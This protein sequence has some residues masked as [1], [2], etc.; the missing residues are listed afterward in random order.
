MFNLLRK[1]F[2]KGYTILLSHQE[3]LSFSS[4]NLSVL[5]MVS[6]SNFSCSNRCVMVSNSH[7]IYF[8]LMSNDI[9]HLPM[10]LFA[11]FI[12]ILFDELCCPLLKIRLF[13]EYFMYSR[14][15]YFM[16]HMICRYFFLVCGFHFI[17]SI[18]FFWRGVFN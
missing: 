2:S 17:R 6:L 7:F 13:S 18:F 14:Y 16:W 4:S 8:S 10:W 5:H 12:Y 9:K 15:K 1:N 11:L 3:C